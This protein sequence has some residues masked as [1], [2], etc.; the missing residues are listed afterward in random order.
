MICPPTSGAGGGVVFTVACGRVATVS[1]VPP[2]AVTVSVAGATVAVTDELTLP[3][4]AVIDAVPAAIAVTSPPLTVA[5]L[6]AEV[7]HVI[8]VV[9]SCPSALR[10]TAL[11]VTVPPTVSVP[12]LDGE[13]T[14]DAGTLVF[15]CVLL[16]LLV[17][18]SAPPPHATAATATSAIRRNIERRITSVGRVSVSEM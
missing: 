9:R 7:D 12:K 15:V 5:T 2:A 11:S 3:A 4:A 13:I 17:G 1:P 10:A 16:L 6:A 18:T 8:V 14:T